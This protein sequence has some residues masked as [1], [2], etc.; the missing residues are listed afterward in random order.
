MC[1]WLCTKVV[2]PFKSHLARGSGLG[3]RIPVRSES[4]SINL[5]FLCKADP[6]KE[7]SASRSDA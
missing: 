1:E 6:N 3:R 2:R 5:D 4:H 7:V